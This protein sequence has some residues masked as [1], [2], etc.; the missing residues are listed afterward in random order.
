[1]QPLFLCIRDTFASHE[2]LAVGC[3]HHILTFDNLPNRPCPRIERMI[4]GHNRTRLCKPI[5]LNNR[6]TS[7]LPEFFQRRI[8]SRTSDDKRPKLPS[9]T[10]M[11]FKKSLTREESHQV[12]EHARDARNHG[13]AVVMHE[14]NEPAGVYFRRENRRDFKK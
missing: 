10:A 2:D 9:Q 5:T 12:F 8:D 7:S 6:K 14:S 11:L 4:H 13:H 3:N 1:M